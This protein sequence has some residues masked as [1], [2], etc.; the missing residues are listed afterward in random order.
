MVP[1]VCRHTTGESRRQRRGTLRAK[2]A[3]LISTGPTVFDA[4]RLIVAELV[5]RQFRALMQLIKKLIYKQLV[6]NTPSLKLR[7]FRTFLPP[8]APHHS[9]QKLA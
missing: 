7:H 5:N 1:G 9:S 6:I 2:R 4:V 3:P 8:A